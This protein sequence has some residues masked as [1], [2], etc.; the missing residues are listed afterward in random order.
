MR[1]KPTRR[2]RRRGLLRDT[3]R[4]QRQR[5]QRVA[6]GAGRNRRRV[7]KARRRP[8]GADGVGDADAHGKAET[9][10]ARDEIRDQRR[11]AAEQMGAAGDVE[12]HAVG[13]IERGERRIAPAPVGDPLQQVR[14]GARVFL[15]RH[16][17][18][19][20]GARLRQRHRHPQARSLG[21]RIDGDQFLGIAAPAG[22]HQRARIRRPL[23]RD[24]VGRQPLQ[25]QAGD[26]L[27]RGRNAARHCSTPTPTIPGCPAGCV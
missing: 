11:L 22:D 26:P 5:R 9:G 3:Q 8:G 4:L 20:H 1:L 16:Q 19:M 14:I 24:A 12:Q 23:P 6:F 21:R 7:G 25:P 2:K 27:P 13:R 18:G 10:D 15:D 17:I